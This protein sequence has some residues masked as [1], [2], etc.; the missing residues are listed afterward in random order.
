MVNHV[1]SMTSFTTQIWIS[2]S[3]CT[4]AGTGRIIT[5]FGEGNGGSK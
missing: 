1:F 5:E 3:A 2:G 4:I